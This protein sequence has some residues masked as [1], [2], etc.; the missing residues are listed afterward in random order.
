MFKQFRKKYESLGRIG[1]T[2]PTSVLTAEE[3]EEIASFFGVPAE[4][5]KRKKGI[6]MLAFAE[7]LE[8]TR[9]AGT[10][11][12]ALLD[13][14]FD[15]TII[16]KRAE[17]E[18]KAQATQQFF[19]ELKAAYPALGFWLDQLLNGKGPGRWIVQLG[20]KQ[21]EYA[22]SLIDQLHAAWTNMPAT[23]ERLPIFS[24]RITG[25]PHAFDLHTDL[26]KMF[27]HLLT[28][29]ESIAFKKIEAEEFAATPT[30]TER[31]NELLQTYHIYR[32]DL[33]NFVTS[34]GLLAETDA[35]IHPVWQAAVQQ[36][37]VQIVPLRELTGLKRI[38]PAKG[39]K[40]VWVVENSGV[41][42]TLLDHV[43][44]SPIVCTNGQFTLAALILM[45]RLVDEGC[46]LFYAGDL[47]PEGLGMAERLL[48][49]YP[50]GAISLWYMDQEAYRFSNPV[51]PL[52]AERLEK[53]NSI[54]HQT[55]KPIAKDMS[56]L[57]K[58]G[59]QESLVHLMTA[60]M[61]QRGKKT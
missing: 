15:E 18:Q 61:K 23:A 44:H 16:S 10:D 21:P 14:Y 31:I 39:E 43:S 36:N 32:D 46:T 57:G 33:L 60:D 1:G 22:A 51:K 35:G 13:A 59:Y 24:E 4:R 9:F 34:S 7:Q 26:G 45:D 40:H 52:S 55:L 41:C 5:L 53:L 38:Y 50:E 17:R 3:L 2:V 20:Q 58:A 11:F 42:A 54:T 8:Q 56:D 12:K 19:V 25:D 48:E 28:A 27:L 47:D 6:S 37:T 30:S 29:A 49:R